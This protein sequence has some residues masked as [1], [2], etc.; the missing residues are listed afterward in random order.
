MTIKT[1]ALSALFSI[2]AI[3][4]VNATTVTFDQTDLRNGTVNAA[5]DEVLVTKGG[6]TL[7]AATVGGRV[8][9]Y[10]TGNPSSNSDGLYIAKPD[11]P[12]YDTGNLTAPTSGTYA[13]G[14]TQQVTSLSFD[15]DW[16]TNT[17]VGQETL[18]NFRADLSTILLAT[19]NLV[20]SDTSLDLVTQT[21][22]A[23]SAT[24]QTSR[25]SGTI[26]YSGAPF[27]LFIFDHAQAASNIGFT[28]TEVRATVA[29][30]PLPA[31][32]PLLA[33]G[34]GA[35]AVLRRKSRA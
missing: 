4:S 3:T 15:F 21:I 24:S 28:I 9:V 5:Q 29:P 33:V 27:N 1:W 26:T 16:L 19:S 25:G 14:F 2:A 23:P 7:S 8:G 17:N 31:G 30:V 6:L 35:F 34:L 32:L 12:P 10:Q 18:S 13:L 22:T 20:S 11:A